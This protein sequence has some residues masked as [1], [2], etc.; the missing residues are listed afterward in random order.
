MAVRKANSKILI[1][2]TTVLSDVATVAPSTDHTDGTWNDTDIYAGELMAHIGTDGDP[3]TEES[4]WLNTDIAMRNIPLATNRGT[5]GQIL[6]KDSLNN[7]STFTDL[8]TIK[9]S[10]SVGL[11]GA[12]AVVLSSDTVEYTSTGAAQ[13]LTLANGTLGQRLMIAYVAEGAAG[14]SAVLT[15]TTLLGWTT[16]TF[17]DI[18]DTLSLE[19]TT[20]G[21]A[22]ISAFNT[23]IA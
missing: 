4:L 21:W 14:D 20:N 5:V 10:D 15:P 7:T 13:A 19:Y 16:A 22:V 18:G 1:K 17:N 9:V 23:T 2:R 8:S 12:G 6:V 11:S 3:A